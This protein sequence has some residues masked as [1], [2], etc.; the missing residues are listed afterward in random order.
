MPSGVTSYAEVWIEIEAII[1]K[2][3]KK[4][5]TSYAEVWIEMWKRAESVIG[6]SSPPTRRCGLKSVFIINS[7]NIVVVTSYAEVWI[8]ISSS[9]F[10]LWCIMSPPTRR[11]GLKLQ[12]RTEKGIG[13]RHLL[14]GGVD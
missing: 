4:K 9:A 12:E 3:M 10:L 13:N 5:V 1:E 8:E 6:L 7:G 11:C 2:D 14:R